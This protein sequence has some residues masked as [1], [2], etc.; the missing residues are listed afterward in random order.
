MRLM[1]MGIMAPKTASQLEGLE[2]AG[3][4]TDTIWN[5]LT[6][7]LGKFSGAMDKQAGT[8]DGMM[9]TFSDSINMTLATAGKPLFDMLK[10]VLSG[11]N[12]LVASPAF[13][14]ALESATN[15]IAAGFSALGDGL[16]AAWTVVQPVL[17]VIGTLL[18]GMSGGAADASTAFY[19]LGSTIAGFAEGVLTSIGGLIQQI[20]PQFAQMAGKAADWIIA[21]LPGF[22]TTSRPTCR[23]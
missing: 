17:S 16:S 20:V 13:Q 6:G 18:S 4:S 8:F 22:P 9:S 19:G 3:A 1:E 15:A 14:G 10:N 21:A 5:T 7:S 23:P 12:N 2:K 11:F